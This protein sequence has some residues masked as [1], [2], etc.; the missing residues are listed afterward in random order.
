MKKNV[1]KKLG[2]GYDRMV[3]RKGKKK[4]RETRIQLENFLWTTLY[5][6]YKQKDIDK[7]EYM[8]SRNYNKENR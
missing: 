1:R 7:D 6:K 5:A 2:R 3:A 8:Y 4:R